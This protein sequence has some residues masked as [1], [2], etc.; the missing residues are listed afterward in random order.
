MF[1]SL[2]TEIQELKRQLGH[3]IR[4]N[5]LLDRKLQQLDKRIGLLIANRNNLDLIFSSEKKRRKRKR[6]GVLDTR[7]FDLS[8]NPRKLEFYEELFYMLQTEPQ[9]LAKCVYLVQVSSLSIILSPRTPP[10]IT[11]ILPHAP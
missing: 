1:F 4:R 10:P 9:Y 5:H 8:K 11:L 3:E 2:N 6:K 7:V